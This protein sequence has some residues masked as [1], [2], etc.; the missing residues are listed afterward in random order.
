MNKVVYIMLTLLIMYGCNNKNSITESTYSVC[1]EYKYWEEVSD[2]SPYPGIGCSE[3]T[4]KNVN[5]TFFV[6][7]DYE[8]DNYI[9]NDNSIAIGVEL[10]NSVYNPHGINF[11][12]GEIVY[13]DSPLPSAPEYAPDYGEHLSIFDLS[14]DVR[15]KYNYNN[16]NIILITN[17]WGAYGKYPW[18][19]TNYYTVMIKAS[20]I[21][22]SFIPSHEIGHFLGLHHTFDYSENVIDKDTGDLTPI[23]QVDMYTNPPMGSPVNWV[24]P[25]D[26]CFAT[27]D[28]ICDTSYDCYNF[29]EEVL[30]CS[31]AYLYEEY[32]PQEQSEYEDCE[33]TDYTP[34]TDNLMSYY[35][36]RQFITEQQGARARFYLKYKSTNNLNG[37][38]LN[39][40]N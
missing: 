34:P 36:D 18:S 24:S 37:N 29:C 4:T 6:H 3:G 21:E 2:A 35:G 14:Q 13:I 5:I 8:N 39:L 7:K 1:D 40:Y 26:D 16:L 30:G 19:D 22:T 32:K 15:D 31:G 25:E 38:I 9:S 23:D 12:I 33:L 11:N 20:S 27:G 10:I 17:E 28:F